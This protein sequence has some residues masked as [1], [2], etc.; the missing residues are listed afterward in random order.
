IIADAPD[1]ITVRNLA[2]RLAEFVLAAMSLT[3]ET[4]VAKYGLDELASLLADKNYD[5][6]FAAALEKIPDD[7]KDLVRALFSDAEGKLLNGGKTIKEAVSAVLPLALKEGD[8]A[9]PLADAAREDLAALIDALKEKTLE[10]YAKTEHTEEFFDLQLKSN[11]DTIKNSVPRLREI[12]MNMLCRTNKD[13]SFKDELRTLVTFITQAHK[14]GFAHYNELYIA[15]MR[16]ADTALVLGDLPSGELDDAALHFLSASS[17]LRYTTDGTTPTAS[18]PLYDGSVVFPEPAENCAALYTVTALPFESGEQAGPAQVIGVYTATTLPEAVSVTETS[19]TVYG[20]YDQEYVLTQKYVNPKW[21]N[22]AVPDKNGTVV[23][24]GLDPNTQYTVHTRIAAGSGENNNAV[25]TTDFKTAKHLEPVTGDFIPGGTV[26]I[27]PASTDPVAMVFWFTAPDG[28]GA[29]ETYNSLDMSFGAS[30]TV[31]E[32]AAGYRIYAQAYSMSFSVIGEGVTPLIKYGEVTFKSEG[33]NVPEPVNG[34]KFGDKV[35]K[36]A[37]DPIFE[38]YTFDGWYINEELTSPYD[39]DEG[40]KGSFTLYA[41]FAP[42]TYTLTVVNGTADSGQYKTG[43]KVTVKAG[44]APAGMKFDKWTGDGVVFEN[45]ASAETTFTMPG[46]DATVTATFK[47]KPSSSGSSSGS[48]YSAPTA[49]AST[50]APGTAAGAATGAGR[51]FADVKDSDWYYDAVYECF[52]KGYFKGV[53]ETS[54]APSGNM[55]RAMFCT[56]LYRMAGEPKTAGKNPFTDVKDGTWYA[57]AVLW[58]YE[59]G[60]ASGYGN[61]VF[62]VNDPVTREQAVTLLWRLSSKPAGDVS[63]LS[64]FSDADKISDWAL[65]AFAWAAGVKIISG[66]GGGV[67]DPKAFALRSEIAQTVINYGRLRAE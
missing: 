60:V 29:P 26:T 13:F 30:L 38:G 46:K 51:P 62:G 53:S 39:F 15:W 48:Y 34:L 59:K 56:V 63:S 33:E 47:K 49:D 21:E 3:D 7:K 25:K 10:A 16:A 8:T 5:G 44:A 31:P 40:V 52:D 2:E 45:A 12:L 54:F 18:S 67:L 19:I 66:K 35:A 57:D 61:G 65:D 24:A 32:S 11:F 6:F 55:T 37:S 64:S 1:N 27:E 20:V 14:I 50:A 22:A 9:R 41:K 23:F 4:I 17:E 28:E 36:P 58:A 42:N 43:E